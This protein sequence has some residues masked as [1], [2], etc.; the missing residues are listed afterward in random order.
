ME[1]NSRIIIFC[2]FWTIDFWVT[3][4]SSVESIVKEEHLNNDTIISSSNLIFHLLNNLS[5]TESEILDRYL[6]EKNYASLKVM[7]DRKRAELFQAKDKPLKSFVNG[8][9]REPGNF[10][11]D[12]GETFS[13]AAVP[14]N[15]TQEQ[16]KYVEAYRN[17]TIYSIIQA[18]W[19]TKVER[20]LPQIDQYAILEYFSEKRAKKE[21]EKNILIWLWNIIRK[22]FDRKN[23]KFECYANEPKCVRA[24]LDRCGETELE[25]LQQATDNNEPM[26][27][28]DFIKNKLDD[29]SEMNMEFDKWNNENNVPEALKEIIHSLSQAQRRAMEKL[30]RLELIDKIKDFYRDNIEKTSLAKQQEIELFFRRMNR[31]F[32]GCY[33]P[34]IKKTKER[35]VFFS[36][37]RLPRC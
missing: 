30:R 4:T 7:I 20:E 10:G 18:L 34:S 15:F 36:K 19:N 17:A 29:D 12:I 9:Q 5:S 1:F 22:W 3:T 8:S 35:Q 32:A 2:V 21:A 13:N 33:N 23:D 11:A 16:F 28:N 27:V 24:V 26:L 37:Q 25:H 14:L 6:C 31:T